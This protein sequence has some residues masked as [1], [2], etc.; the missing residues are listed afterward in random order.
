MQPTRK[1]CQLEQGLGGNPNQ[2]CRD[3]YLLRNL[4]FTL[5]S[6]KK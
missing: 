3:M 4:L 5:V 2:A 6:A 1:P